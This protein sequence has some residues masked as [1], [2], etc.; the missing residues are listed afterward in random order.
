MAAAGFHSRYLNGPLP[1]VRHY[2]LIKAYITLLKWVE[3]V[4]L[5]LSL[6]L[7]HLGNVLFNDALN[8]FYLQLYGA[9][10]FTSLRLS[11]RERSFYHFFSFFD[12]RLTH[13]FC[14]AKYKYSCC[15]YT[16]HYLNRTISSLKLRNAKCRNITAI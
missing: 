13:I 14:P 16:N 11:Y 6:S 8:T 7:S 5:S 10:S 4:S 2:N 1:Y 15:T 3:C 9:L 12:N